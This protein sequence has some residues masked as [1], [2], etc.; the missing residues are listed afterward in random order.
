MYPFIIM[1][2][3]EQKKSGES[4]P[5]TRRTDPKSGSMPTESTQ[6]GTKKGPAEFEKGKKDSSGNDSGKPS[7]KQTSQPQ[8]HGNDSGKPSDKQSSQPQGHGNKGHPEKKK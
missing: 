8:G 7:D 1:S 4:K 5:D 2:Q 3:T 6:Q